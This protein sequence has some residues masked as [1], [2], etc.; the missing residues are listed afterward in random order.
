MKREPIIKLKTTNPSKKRYIVR[1]GPKFGGLKTIKSF[2]TVLQAKA[3]VRKLVDSDD[4]SFCNII[5]RDTKT[6]E[7]W[8]LTPI[9][10]IEYRGNIL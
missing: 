7:S 10:E 9:G 3:Y 5:I 8:G 1:A 6:F 2:D 4:K